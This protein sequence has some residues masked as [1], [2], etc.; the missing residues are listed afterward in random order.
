MA[1]LQ[2]SMLDWVTLVRHSR[3]RLSSYWYRA[4][5]P[6]R[7]KRRAKRPY[8]MPPFVS[9]STS[10]TSGS[11]GNV[12]LTHDCKHKCNALCFIKDNPETR[13][14]RSSPCRSDCGLS[15][16]GPNDLYVRRGSTGISHCGGN[17]LFPHCGAVREAGYSSD[18]ECYK[19]NPRSPT[20][21]DDKRRLSITDK[22]GKDDG[23][24]SSTG[25]FVNFLTKKKK[26]K[27]KKKKGTDNMKT[28]L[29]S[30]GHSTNE[31]NGGEIKNRKR[32]QSLE[33]SMAESHL[34]KHA[35][36]MD[37]QNELG[38]KQS[39][40]RNCHRKCKSDFGMSARDY[41]ALLTR[42][43][44]NSPAG[45]SGI[46]SQHPTCIK[47]SFPHLQNTCS[48]TTC[49]DHHCHHYHTACCS[50]NFHH[51]HHHSSNRNNH[52]HLRVTT[53]DDQPILLQH[54][55]CNIQHYEESPYQHHK[56]RRRR[57]RRS[58]GSPQQRGIYC[59]PY[60]SE[61]RYYHRVGINQ[62][63]KCNYNLNFCPI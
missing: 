16:P 25:S 2:T 23:G 37:R 59:D 54:S 3:R 30:D 24:Y 44:G 56:R 29:E 26:N 47:N 40:H 5:P 35:L 21:S 9:H 57:K 20:C 45:F 43:A 31:E 36:E 14:E 13:F 22:S 28:L 38:N 60:E 27:K 12:H 17:R 4:G 61:G 10:E 39:C 55:P 32:K 1:A 42:S 15:P 63:E 6:G 48:S 33:I 52:P 51:H 11:A 62:S 46:S 7:R 50:N 34:M 18:S 49:K 53:P 8:S 58:D 19:R 41:Q